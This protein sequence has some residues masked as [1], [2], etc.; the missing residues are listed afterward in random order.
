MGE[1]DLYLIGGLLRDGQGIDLCKQ[2]RQYDSRKPV[3]LFSTLAFD[4]DRERG[5]CAGVHAYLVKPNDLDELIPTISRLLH[6]SG[7]SL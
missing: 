3:I 4:T 2:L 1:F 5:R 6:R 7:P